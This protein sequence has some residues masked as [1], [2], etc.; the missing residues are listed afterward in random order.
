MN[1]LFVGPIS[2]TPCAD[3]YRAWVIP[4][5]YPNERQPRLENWSA[6]DKEAFCGIYK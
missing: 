4:D 6:E 5:L 2:S 3:M 1:D